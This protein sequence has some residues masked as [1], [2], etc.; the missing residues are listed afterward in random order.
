MVSRWWRALLL[1]FQYFTSVKRTRGAQVYSLTFIRGL[2]N[3]F[4]L[5]GGFVKIADISEVTHDSRPPRTDPES[6]FGKAK[7]WYSVRRSAPRITYETWAAHGCGLSSA[8]R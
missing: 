3:T 7:T 4:G 1:W 8:A 6:R 5:Q 2:A